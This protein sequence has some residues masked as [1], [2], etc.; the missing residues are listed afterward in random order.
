MVRNVVLVS[1]DP[2]L[3]AILQ[4]AFAESGELT[5]VAFFGELPD[6]PDDNVDVVVLDQPATARRDAYEQIRERYHA[7]L[8]LPVDRRVEAGD[9]PDDPELE[10]LVRPFQVAELVDSVRERAPAPAPAQGKA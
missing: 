4:L 10:V 8:L 9:W 3:G 5:I 1:A 6:A 7:R 2:E